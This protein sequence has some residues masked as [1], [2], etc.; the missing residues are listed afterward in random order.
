MHKSTDDMYSVRGIFFFKCTISDSVSDS[1]VINDSGYF[2]LTLKV[3]IRTTY[4]TAA[5]TTRTR[6]ISLLK[7]SSSTVKLPMGGK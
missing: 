2:M 1:H 7:F 5:T 3:T 4:T 6:E